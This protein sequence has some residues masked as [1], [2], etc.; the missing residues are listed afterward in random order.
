VSL[1]GSQKTSIKWFELN[2]CAW[3]VKG[4]GSCPG[5]IAADF[6]IRISDG[7]DDVYDITRI[8]LCLAH[9]RDEISLKWLMRFAHAIALK[10]VTAL[11]HQSLADIRFTY[12]LVPR[13]PKKGGQKGE[14]SG[15]AVQS[16]GAIANEI[17]AKASPA[18]SLRERPFT[19]TFAIP[20]D[21]TTGAQTKTPRVVARAK[22]AWYNLTGDERQ[23]YNQIAE[24]KGLPGIYL[25]MSRFVMA[26]RKGN[27]PLVFA[28]DIP[29]E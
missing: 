28:D 26:L 3:N 14:L 17:S 5:G 7:P 27:G 16:P 12:R 13:K 22:K 9:S 10:T 23:F 19:R 29:P 20:S 4:N 25:F 1:G 18:S 11:R 21:P 8:P 24:A 2:R 15:G 6:V